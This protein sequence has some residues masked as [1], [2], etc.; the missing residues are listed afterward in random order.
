MSSLSVKEQCGDEG[1]HWYGTRPQD[2]TADTCLCGQVP[3]DVSFG[4]QCSCGVPRN[5]AH[6][7]SCDWVQWAEWR[8]AWVDE[9]PE[10]DPAVAKRYPQVIG[11]PAP[12]VLP[13]NQSTVCPR[14]ETRLWLTAYEELECL[15][16]GYVNYHYAP[17]NGKAFSFLSSATTFVVRYVGAFPALEE[18]LTEMRSQRVKNRVVYAVNC[19]WCH[20]GMRLVSPAGK[21]K[22]RNQI[23]YECSVR[24]RISLRPAENALGLGWE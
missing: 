20:E 13:T 14:C 21:R 1:H 12:D 11:E 10:V 3:A 6:W 24:H 17:T 8:N 2:G 16:C 5:S 9:H 18:T 15:L 22:D 23:R 4:G 7:P 19:P